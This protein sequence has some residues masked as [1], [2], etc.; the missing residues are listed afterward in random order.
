MFRR[1][2]GHR[3]KPSTPADLSYTLVDDRT[4]QHWADQEAAQDAAF[5]FL[6][7]MLSKVGPIAEQN[8]TA[9]VAN[10]ADVY[11]NITGIAREAR[12]A[13]LHALYLTACAH[14]N[15]NAIKAWNRKYG[16]TAILSHDGVPISSR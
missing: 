9:A 2:F 5:Q 13:R 11:R 12:K 14:G 7:T 10:G 16:E 6:E 1:F 15:T 4:L 8:V 3:S